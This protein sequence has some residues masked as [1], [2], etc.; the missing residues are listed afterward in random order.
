M[1]MR[2]LGCFIVRLSQEMARWYEGGDA[3][4]QIVSCGNFDKYITASEWK[5]LMDDAMK[6]VGIIA[7]ADYPKGE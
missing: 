4:W 2:L 7:D 5:K 1:R 3:C 6:D